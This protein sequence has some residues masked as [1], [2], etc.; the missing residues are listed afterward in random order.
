[1]PPRTVRLDLPCS[2]GGEKGSLETVLEHA[3]DAGI[4]R[5]SHIPRIAQSV[6]EADLCLMAGKKQ[7]SDREICC[8]KRGDHSH[9]FSKAS[10]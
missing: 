9:G 4:C 2:L 7:V 1:M 5:F 8:A 3:Q 6:G 10:S